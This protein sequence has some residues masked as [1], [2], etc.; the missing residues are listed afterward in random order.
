MEQHEFPHELNPEMRRQAVLDNERE[1]FS[2]ELVRSKERLLSRFRRLFLATSPL[3]LLAV[4][5]LM[6][7][8][9]SPSEILVWGLWGLG[10]HAIAILSLSWKIAKARRRLRHWDQIV[11]DCRE[12]TW[13]DN[14]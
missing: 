1:R 11:D 9:A 12:L 10:P 2:V 6:R 13:E 3:P 14:D 5:W 8:S 4:L 7:P